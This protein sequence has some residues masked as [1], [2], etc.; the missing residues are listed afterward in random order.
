[1]TEPARLAEIRQFTEE[2]RARNRLVPDDDPR[3]ILL[4]HLDWLAGEVERLREVVER[5]EF[6]L[7]Q[8]F[9][10]SSDPPRRSE[11]L[12]PATDPGT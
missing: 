2:I 3:R 6:D 11:A 10:I 8:E 7:D 5:L 9:R 4:G 1:M 12:P